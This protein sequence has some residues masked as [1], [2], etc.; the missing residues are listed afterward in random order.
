MMDSTPQIIRGLSEQHRA[1]LRA[2]G[3][4]DE[5]ITA[6]GCYT[7]NDPLKLSGMLNR[8]YPKV[9]GAGLVFPFPGMNGELTAFK[10]V[11]PDNPRIDQNGRKVKYE[12]PSGLPNRAYFPSQ[13]RHILTDAGSELLLTEGEKKALK[14]S[15]EGFPCIGLTGVYGWKSGKGVDRLIVDLQPIKWR[16][17]QV[18]IVYDSDADTKPEVKEAENRLAAILQLFGAKV[19]VARLPHGPNGEKV[20]LDDYLLTHD[21]TELRK[22]LDGAGDPEPPEEAVE[23][24]KAH[25]LDTAPEAQRFIRKVGSQ[26]GQLL[27]RHWQGSFFGHDGRRY[28]KLTDDEMRQRVYSFIEPLVSHINRSVIFNL[29]MCIQA[30]C[31]LPSTVTIPSWLDGSD[32]EVIALQNGLLDVQAWLDGSDNCLLPHS[33]KWFSTTCLP[34]VFDPTA[35][36]PIWR[37]VIARNLEHDSARIALA[38]EWAGYLTVRD[39]SQQ[40]CLLAFGEG[41]NG[42]S[43]FFAL[44]RALLGA[45]NVSSVQLEVFGER[46][47][48]NPTLGKLANIVSEI[49]ELDRIAEGYFKSFVSGDAMQFEEKGK[50]PFMAVP[51]ARLTFATNNLPRFSDRSLGIWR[52]ILL[53]PFTATIPEHERLPGLDKPEYWIDSGELPGVLNWALHGLRRLRENGRFTDAEACR[54]ALEEYRTESNPARAFLVDSLIESPNGTI[55]TGDVYYRYT[56]WCEGNGYRRLAANTFGKEIVRA[57][58]KAIKGKAFNSMGERRDGY[59]GID[60]V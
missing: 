60:E 12:S 8:K 36:C 23:K 48:L 29:M 55:V 40:K 43:V 18:R 22:L 42:K 7:E 28:R 37:S 27:L 56:Q 57:F 59:H 3:L 58:P 54:Q 51:T 26:N 39:T 24:I 6:S 19:K 38:Q 53:L 30:E 50:T 5:T 45:E 20:G 46:F 32:R 4:S 49:G 13:V 15:Q 31:Q 11:K 47:Q 44:L 25:E 2:S 14:A 1:E 41:A 33:P 10:R 34:Y 21:R 35:D 52:R 9:R 16:D 17:R